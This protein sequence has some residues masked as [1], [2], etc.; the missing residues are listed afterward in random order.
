MLDKFY[1]EPLENDIFSDF[2]DS[3]TTHGATSTIL[4]QFLGATVTANLMRNPPMYQT[5]IFWLRKAQC[6]QTLAAAAAAGSWKTLLHLLAQSSLLVT[7]L[8]WSC[9]WFTKA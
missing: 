7:R 5:S 1:Q 8:Y 4:E 6:A 9:Y 2:F 3:T